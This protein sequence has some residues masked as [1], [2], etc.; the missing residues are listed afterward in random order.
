MGL[1]LEFDGAGEEAVGHL[2]RG[3]MADFRQR[4]QI[5]CPEIANAD[6]ANLALPL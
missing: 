4:G 3:A 1:D 6:G 5:P 2:V